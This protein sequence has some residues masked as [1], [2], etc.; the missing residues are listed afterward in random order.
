[1]WA[2]DRELPSAYTEFKELSPYG[3]LKAIVCGKSY[4]GIGV[5]V[6]LNNDWIRVTKVLSGSP[7]EKVEIKTDDVITHINRKS[8]SELTPS[9]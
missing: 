8:V 3:T 2:L 6:G 5:L 7:A 4:G 9:R 1:M